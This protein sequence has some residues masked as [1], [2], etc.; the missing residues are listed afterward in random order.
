MTS[1]GLVYPS[2]K[3]SRKACHQKKLSFFLNSSIHQPGLTFYYRLH[4]N[5]HCSAI[6]CRL[7]VSHL[8]QLGL[9]LC[10]KP[11]ILSWGQLHPG[12]LH[13]LRHDRLIRLHMLS[14]FLS[15]YVQPLS[16]K[17]GEWACIDPER[18]TQ[19]LHGF[20][21][22]KSILVGLKL[23]SPAFGFCG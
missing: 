22:S 17:H 16:N 11:S 18:L 4:H 14:P 2:G 19:Y 13:S 9:L 10:K 20:N 7:Y 23:A 12:L 1:S 21:L 15:L 8:F 5:N 6:Q 3:S